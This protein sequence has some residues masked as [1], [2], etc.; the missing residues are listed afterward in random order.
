MCPSG[1]ICNGAGCCQSTTPPSC[2]GS[3]S[4]LTANDDG[5]VNTASNCWKTTGSTAGISAEAAGGCAASAGC[6]TITVDFYFKDPSTG[7][8]CN[9]KNGSV[10]Q[11]AQ[12]GTPEGTGA[13]AVLDADGTQ[14]VGWSAEVID[15]GTMTIQ[16][17]PSA[18]GDPFSF[19]LAASVEMTPSSQTVYIS[20]SVTTTYEP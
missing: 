10:I 11:L 7:L 20:G 8:P 9:W 5:V 12:T 18:A 14:P 16:K 17:W 15:S 1:Y 4:D 3:T 6:L 13:C 2:S 19:T